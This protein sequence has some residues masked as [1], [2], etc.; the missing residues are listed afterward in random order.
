MIHRKG[1][2]FIWKEEGQ[3]TDNRNQQ[4]LGKLANRFSLHFLK[5][6]SSQLEKKFPNTHGGGEESI[7]I[8]KL[9][10]Q[11]IK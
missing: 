4:D 6:C 10:S 9:F 8:S 1:R 11:S 7:I 3:E 2:V 5:G